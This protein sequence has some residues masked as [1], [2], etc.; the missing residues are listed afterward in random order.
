MQFLCRYLSVLRRRFRGV[1]D[2]IHWKAIVWNEDD[3]GMTFETIEIPEDLQETV[4]EYREK[5]LESVA[6]YDES[7]MEKFFED[8]DSISA[9]EIRKA[10]REAVIDMS[11][12]PMMC[13]SAFKNKGVQAVLDAVCCIH[14]FSTGRMSYHRYV[15]PDTEEPKSVARQCRRAICFFGV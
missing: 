15:N 3:M 7:L 8:P 13:G 4:A 14:A 1:V 2:L 11:I 5:L 12:V 6:E 9:E 10:I